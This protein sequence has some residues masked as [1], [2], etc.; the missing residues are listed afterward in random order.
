MIGGPSNQGKDGHLHEDMMKNLDEGDL[1]KFINEQSSRSSM[2]DSNSFRS[3]NLAGSTLRQ[4][5]NLNLNQ[6]GMNPSDS[7]GIGMMPKANPTPTPYSK[8]G[9]VFQRQDSSHSSSNVSKKKKK[10]GMPPLQ[11][12]LTMGVSNSIM[13]AV[14]EHTEHDNHSRYDDRQYQSVHTPIDMDEQYSNQKTPKNVQQQIRHHLQ[15]AQ[16]E[17]FDF[18]EEEKMSNAPDSVRSSQHLN[19]KMSTPINNHH[20]NGGGSHAKLSGFGSSHKQPKQ[21]SPL[22]HGH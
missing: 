16:I 22:M 18:Y 4:S 19:Q 13:S 2:T 9:K 20:S 3:D 11:K 6:N 7:F 14:D 17:N 5:S 15:L 10:P 21:H 12:K 8:Q 1:D